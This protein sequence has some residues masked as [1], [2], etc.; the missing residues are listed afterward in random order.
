M[1]K[2]VG[3]PVLSQPGSGERRRDAEQAL[4]AA[5]E[6]LLDEG[7][8][9]AELSVERIAARAGRPRTAFYLYFRDKREL[10]ERL[11][12]AVAERLYEESDRWWSGEDGR[13]DLRAALGDLLVTYREHARLIGAVV[14]VSGYDAEVAGLWRGIMDRFVAATARRLAAEGEETGAA[15]KAF[16]LCWMAERS[17]YQ[18]FQRAARG[19][20]VADDELLDA[21]TEV[22]ERAI[23]G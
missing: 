1:S 16:V 2:M 7:A 13:R 21:L 22:W 3:M 4:L 19:E 11:T 14:D 17:L 6:A 5:A 10:L 12:E 20:D 23:Y 8:P 9:F 15:S 18:H